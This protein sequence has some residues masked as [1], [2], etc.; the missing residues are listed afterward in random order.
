MLKKTEVWILK[1]SEY[2]IT[3][4]GFQMMDVRV[5]QKEY[6]LIHPVRKNLLYRLSI[7]S[8]FIL[9]KENERVAQIHQTIDK[10]LETQST[11]YDIKVDEEGDAYSTDHAQFNILIS[12]QSTSNPFIIEHQSI[13]DILTKA[14]EPIEDEKNM[15]EKLRQNI[16]KKTGP[17]AKL[18]IKNQPIVT[19]ALMN[20]MLFM[21]MLV[22]FSMQKYD[23]ASRAIFY[24]AYYKTFILAN[25]EYWRFL[26]VGLI[27]ADLVHLVMNMFALFNLGMILER[28]YGKVKFLVLI[29]I[30]TISGSLFLFIAQGNTL[31]V[32]ISGGLYA[33]LGALFIY[34]IETGLIKQ[35][36]VRSQL[37]RLVIINVLINTLPNVSFVAHMGGLMA[38]LIIG[39]LYTKAPNWKSLRLNGAI[40]G[41][42]L[43]VLSIGLA[44]QNIKHDPIYG[45]NNVEVV[46]ML[47]DLGLQSQAN[48]LENNLAKY[49]QANQ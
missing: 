10:L 40:A 8:G 17:K 7:D 45:G 5:N 43:L 23:L 3:K 24:G 35:P 20:I 1:I 41:V 44:T 32:G 21:F 14:V 9:P 42:I 28:L 27:H 13:L 18:L 15:V 16:Y 6:W 47:K 11:F 34:F 31:A 2:L 25:F 22:N 36:A 48:T 4:E 49:Y 12:P 30:G 38:G 26:T 33:C 19:I 29:V 39:L 46:N 37:I